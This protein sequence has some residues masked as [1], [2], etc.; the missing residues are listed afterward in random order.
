[1]KKAFPVGILVFFIL[2]AVFLAALRMVS[3][4]AKGKAAAERYKI[5]YQMVIAHRGLSYL[6]PEATRPAFIIARDMGVDYL[7]MDIQRTKD[8]ALIAYHDETFERTT[9]VKEIF[10]NRVNDPVGSFTL[11]EVKALDAGSWFNARYPERAKK[12]YDGIKILTLEEVIEIAGEGA[13]MPGL[14]IESKDA[15]KYPGIEKE[16]VKQLKRH[17]WIGGPQRALAP[18]IF[19]SF[20]YDSLL[21]FKALAPEVPRVFLIDE[22][23]NKE[24]DWNKLMEQ[25]SDVAQ[26]IGP[27]GYLCFPWNIGRAH[28]RNLVVHIYTINASWQYAIFNYYGAD[29]FFT[30]RADK[31]MKFYGKKAQP[32]L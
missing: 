7:E 14:Y 13:R 8:G 19:Q 17:G 9:D 25:A 24:F 22:K 23:M 28:S 5:P 11:K 31:L 15:E 3:Y 6:A 16:M 27:V 4:P 32:G 18:V 26:C 1:M 20:N 29:G 2:L 30:D 10:P 12:E 21:M